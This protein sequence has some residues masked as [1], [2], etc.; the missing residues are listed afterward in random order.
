MSFS[1]RQS[2]KPIRQVLQTDSMD[3]GLR[4]RL[5]NVFI[6]TCLH[7]SGFSMSYPDN[8]AFQRFCWSL[9]HDHFKMPVDTIP[10]FPNKVMVEIR[11]YFFGCQWYETYDFIEF[12]ANRSFFSSPE[13][14]RTA[15][16]EV[17][18]S[19]L[20]GY[21]FVADKLAP[22]SSEQ[23]RRSVEQAIARTAD[24]Y[25][26]TSEH[27]KQAVTLLARKPNPDYRNSIK[28]SIS[29]VEAI[30]ALITGDPGATLGQALKVMDAQAPLHGALRSA[31]DKLYGYTSDAEGIRHA[32]LEEPTLEQ[33][34]AVFMLVACSAFVSYIIAKR[35]RARR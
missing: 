23:E 10:D 22:V 27:L 17:L 31:F 30:C 1:E 33:E 2:L 8:A 12:V 25:S 9:W 15:F 3:P 19:E 26:P 28:E 13:R 16:N 4:N 32:L 7:Y 24:A 5:W 21:R 18:A 20:S 29:A 6:G 35:A 11:K 14:A 34:D